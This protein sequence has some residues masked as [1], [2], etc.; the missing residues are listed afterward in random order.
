MSIYKQQEFD[1]IER[2]RK[3]LKQYEECAVKLALDKKKEKYEVTL[4]INCFV[5]LLILPK[6]E[7]F[8]SLP[9]DLL[10]VSEWGIDKTHISILKD[11][12]GN[13]E[14]KNVK[15]FTKHLRNSISHYRFTAFENNRQEISK[16]KFEDFNQ[17]GSIKTMEATI[18]IHSL[19]KFLDKFSSEVL[20]RMKTQ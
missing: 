2:T 19:R 12:Q 6:E 4:L 8:N 11:S 17:S 9:T 3:L 13:S 1:F 14:N 7:W 16:I 18:P 5:G 10:S 20:E 15:N